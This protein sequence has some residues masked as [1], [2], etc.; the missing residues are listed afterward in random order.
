M[1]MFSNYFHLIK[2]WLPNDEIIKQDKEKVK[3]VDR[4]SFVVS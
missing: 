3:T 2:S 1:I 4:N